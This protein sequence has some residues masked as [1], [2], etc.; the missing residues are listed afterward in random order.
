MMSLSFSLPIVVD[1][2]ARQEILVGAFL[3]GVG[4]MYILMGL[5]LS[6]MLVA[7]SFGVVG[8]VLGGSLPAPD[9]ARIAAGFLVALGL[10]GAS[11][12]VTRAAVAVLAGLWGGLATFVLVG[13]LGLDS[14]IALVAAGVMFAG[15]ASMAFV[16]YHEIIALVTSLEGTLLFIGGLIIF[17]NQ[18]PAFWHHMRSLLV[19]NSVFAPFLVLAGT[20]VGYYTQIAEL[21]KKHAGR[22]A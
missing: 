8:F 13:K 22:S 19:G 12:W 15:A 16:A 10:A 1:E 6:R 7:M 20:V 18:H 4:L 5:R 2:L 14:Q 3:I 9:E 11:L 17:M 21:Q